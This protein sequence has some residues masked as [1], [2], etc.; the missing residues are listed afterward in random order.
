MEEPAG[1]KVRFAACLSCQKHSES[2]NDAPGEM[3]CPN[4]IVAGP[5]SVKWPRSLTRALRLE[6]TGPP[7]SGPAERDSSFARKGAGA[8]S[9][10]C[11]GVP[12]SPPVRPT[13][14]EKRRVGKGG[15]STGSTWW[16][17]IHSKKKQS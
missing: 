14:E 7:N 6:P 3:D 12:W 16:W 10:P 8:G 11:A 17:Q 15:V 13:R 2:A 1:A 5:R 4:Y 9:R